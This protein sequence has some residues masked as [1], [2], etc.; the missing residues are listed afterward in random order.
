MISQHGSLFIPGTT[1]TCLQAHSHSL[2]VCRKSPQVRE[3]GGKGARA[4]GSHLTLALSST[5]I[6]GY[7][8]RHG[9]GGGGGS[10]GGALGSG[11]AGGGGKG[12]WGAA[13]AWCPCGS[14][15]SWWKWL[16]GLLLTW[17]LLL[18]L[19]FGLIALGTCGRA[20]L[21]VQKGRN[22]QVSQVS[23]ARGPEIMA[24][25]PLFL[26]MRRLGPQE[27]PGQGPVAAP[28]R[29][30]DSKAAPGSQG[31]RAPCQWHPAP[32]PLLPLIIRPDLS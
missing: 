20:L 23:G 25:D 21:P 16:L 12:S 15:C 9:G 13:P 19:L 7:D 30:W 11:A 28:L 1:G 4:A 3:F 24:A 8:H 6:H 32:S 17:L 26:K 5:D 18:G 10:S 31:T 2:R 27:A 14:W 22:Q 29:S